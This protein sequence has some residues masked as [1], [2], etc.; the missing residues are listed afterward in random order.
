M[1][2]KYLSTLVNQG[3]QLLV[4]YKYARNTDEKE[5]NLQIKH[6]KK[7][8][9]VFTFVSQKLSHLEIIHNIFFLFYSLY[10]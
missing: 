4:A 6:V 10:Y 7:R 9:L 1:I 8:K 3:D 2:L 5:F